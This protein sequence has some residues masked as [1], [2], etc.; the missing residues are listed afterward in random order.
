MRGSG[1]LSRSW[2]PPSSYV[3]RLNSPGAQGMESRARMPGSESWLHCFSTCSGELVYS[4]CLAFL[5]YKE[6]M[7]EP[8]SEGS[9]EASVTKCNADPSPWC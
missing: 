7:L 8:S 9:Y 3:E 4:L 6:Q 1:G 2:G 5:T